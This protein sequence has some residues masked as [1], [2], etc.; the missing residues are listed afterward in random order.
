MFYF[1]VLFVQLSGN[2]FRWEEQQRK[3]QHT[4]LSQIWLNISA[5][6]KLYVLH[7]ITFF[8]KFLF[9]AFTLYI[10]K[11]RYIEKVSPLPM[12][13][14][15]F[16]LFLDADIWSH[17]RSFVIHRR[18]HLGLDACF[19]VRSRSNPCLVM[20]STIEVTIFWFSL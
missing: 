6:K 5:S 13:L 19:S 17:T 9:H 4:R 14:N 20:L 2:R 11:I 18:F 3:S 16:F 1:F 15:V 12:N 8:S 7:K 10:H